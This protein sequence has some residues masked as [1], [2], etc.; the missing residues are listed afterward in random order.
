MML[1]LGNEKLV[2]CRRQPA[3]EFRELGCQVELHSVTG[4]HLTIVEQPHIGQIA[5]AIRDKTIDSF[6]SV[7]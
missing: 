1:F 4:N 2:R 7:A 3:D 6:K 5:D